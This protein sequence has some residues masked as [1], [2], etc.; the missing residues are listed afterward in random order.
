MFK[1]DPA[2]GNAPGKVGDPAVA[3]AVDDDDDDAGGVDRTTLLNVDGAW[4]EWP[5]RDD[6]ASNRRNVGITAVMRAPAAHPDG[7]RQ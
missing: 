2:P 6:V 7:E 3:V 4:K 5:V 1:A